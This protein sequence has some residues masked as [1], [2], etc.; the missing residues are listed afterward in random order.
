MKGEKSKINLLSA[1]F[2]FLLLYVVAAL[3]WSYMSLEIQNDL[4]LESRLQHAAN[5]DGE[6]AAR[7]EWQARD[8]FRRKKGQYLGESAVFMGI[9]ILGAFFVYRATRREMA[10]VQ[11]QQ[12]FMM[13]VTHELKTPLAASRLN[14]ETLQKRQLNEDQKNR[15][16]KNTLQENHRLDQLCNNIL[17]ASRFDGGNLRQHH[18]TIDLSELLQRQAAEFEQRHPH[19]PIEV[20]IEAGLRLYGDE[21][22]VGMLVSNLLENAAKY[23]AG[24]PVG[25]QASH[26]DGGIRIAVSDNGP[27]VAPEERKRIFRKFYRAGSENTR[28][29]SGSGL[30]LYLVKK[31]ANGHDARVWVQENQP[32]GAIFTVDF[33]RQPEPKK[34]I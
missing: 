1:A 7:A 8:Y 16:L 34:A 17:W 13:A 28:A 6:A 5:L 14:L 3:V 15:L 19:T 21:M 32:T 25:L 27:G 22:L 26:H 20:D 12:N 11:Q 30:G 31:I 2:I 33:P 29:Q 23:G 9:I 10:F 24:K 4:L 18:S